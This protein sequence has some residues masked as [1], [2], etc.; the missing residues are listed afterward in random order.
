MQTLLEIGVLN[1]LMAVGLAL[2]VACIGRLCRRPALMHLL[3]ILV[4]LKL[5]TPPAMWVPL[6]WPEAWTRAATEPATD[7]AEPAEELKLTSTTDAAP[8]PEDMLE[9][10]TEVVSSDEEAPLPTLE[11]S[12]PPVAAQPME[13]RP[14]TTEPGWSGG[15]WQN[16]AL[17]TW[18]VGSGLWFVVGVWRIYCFNRLLRFG[19][20]A[21][22][23][24]QAEARGLADRMG[25]PRCPELL[26][27]PGKVSPLLWA[28]GGRA[29]LI[30]P[31]ALLRR[32]RPDQLST[33][34]AHELA[35]ARRRD[36]WVRWLELV[37]TSLYWWH[38]VAWW[39][40]HE[41]QQAEEQ[42]CDAWVVHLLPQAAKAYAKALLQ[43]VDFLDSHPALPPVASGVGHVHLLKR[44]LTMI[45]REPLSPRI[46]WPIGIGALCLG[47]LI[48]P[49]APGRLQAKPEKDQTVRFTLD[50]EEPG[51]GAPQDANAQDLEKRMQKLEE[52]MDRLLRTLEAR[53]STSVKTPPNQ[54]EAAAERQTKDAEKKAVEAAKEAQRKARELVRDAQRKA[55]QARRDAE[56]MVAEQK[57][58]VASAKTNE[59]DETKKSEKPR[60]TRFRIGVD[61][62]LDPEQMKKIEKQIHEA[63]HQAL[64]PE[65]MKKLNEQIHKSIDESIS[66]ERMKQLE[67]QIQSAVGG[68]NA[69]RLDAMARQI[70]RAVDQSLSAEQRER[71]M[72]S[73]ESRAPETPRATSARGR[74]ATF[75]TTSQRDLERRLDKL[76]QKMN[77]LI[78]SLESSR[79][80]IQ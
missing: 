57:R 80:P 28:A 75:T 8:A 29:R 26:V 15:H 49:L 12:L 66:P 16:A 58:R 46:P 52:R 21:P 55:E 63:I 30:L 40:R 53:R 56:R 51:A 33:L 23:G 43:T 67:K 9:C 74:T 37:A 62:N 19:K 70:E 11:A 77:K 27:V 68:I 76:E 35:H 45:V 59:S 2:L 3:W 24:L 39:A 14:A 31:G 50:G 18:L 25:L 22:A 4:L 5:I 1:A 60:E 61:G 17:M 32:L 7:A 38:P 48:L 69:Q 36:H 72:R 6:A 41:I 13:S 73:T 71:S 54:P 64:D 44:R 34:L 65:R 10:C 79:K 78:E 42:C 47:L 20:P